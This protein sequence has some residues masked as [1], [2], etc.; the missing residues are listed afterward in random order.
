MFETFGNQAILFYWIVMIWLFLIVWNWG[1]MNA[2]K[3]LEEKPWYYVIVILLLLYLGGSFGK[4]VPG[5]DY[6]EA[7][8]AT[9]QIRLW[10]GK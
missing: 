7:I 4:I 5:V 9:K 10:E 6:I 1:N 2:L 3:W 8:G